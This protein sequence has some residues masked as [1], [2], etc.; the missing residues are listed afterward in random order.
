M[1]FPILFLILEE[2]LFK[3]SSW[4]IKAIKEKKD[5]N[6]MKVGKEGVKLFLFADDTIP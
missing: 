3:N 4:S 1:V 2:T 6:G 5:S